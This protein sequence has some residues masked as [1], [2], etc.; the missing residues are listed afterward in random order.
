M[1]DNNPKWSFEENNNDLFFNFYAIA[2][3][4]NL[5]TRHFK[6]VQKVWWIHT[7]CI[8]VNFSFD[9]SWLS[10]QY[11]RLTNKFIFQSSPRW[12]IQQK[13]LGYIQQ[14]CQHQRYLLEF[15]Q[16]QIEGSP[17]SYFTLLEVY[18]NSFSFQ[19]VELNPVVNRDLQRRARPMSSLSNH[20]VIMYQGQSLVL[21]IVTDQIL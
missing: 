11:R 6:H 5:K 2:S 13:M 3:S 8:Q 9:N 20:N 10:V 12:T 19:D 17:T 14:Q 7:S 15:E 21:R 18:W 1:T 4:N 16:Y